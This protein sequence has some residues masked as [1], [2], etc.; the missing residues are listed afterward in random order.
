MSSNLKFGPETNR[1][2]VPNSGET[3]NFVAPISPA[4]LNAFKNFHSNTLLNESKKN[5]AQINN[6][7]NDPIS[8]NQNSS[9]T[10]GQST[11]TNVLEY[12]LIVYGQITPKTDDITRCKYVSRHD[13]DGKFIYLEPG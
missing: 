8:P 11:N 1:E 12:Y 4:K 9:S 7:T 6:Q 10:S 13:S 5:E 3:T 2:S